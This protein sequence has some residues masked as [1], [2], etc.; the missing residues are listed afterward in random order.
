M[1]KEIRSIIYKYGI[2][3]KAYQKIGNAYIITSDN[4]KY[5]IKLNTN[6]YDI[7]K[8]LVSRD[9]LYFPNNYS[10]DSDNYDLL[11]YIPDLSVS[12][13]QKINDYIYLLGLLHKKTSYKREI[14]LD[15]IK[16]KYESITNKI[17]YLRDYYQN[18]NN[19]IDKEMFLSPSE[20][21]L[22]RN[23]SLIYAILTR[24]Q[25]L[26]N[27]LYNNI[28]NIKSIRVSLLH[29]N[30]SLSHLITNNRVYLISWD[31]AY[32]ASP[33]YEL[34]DFFR[35]YYHDIE[36][37]DLLKNYESVN[38]LDENE[39]SLL[40]ILLSLPKEIKLSNNTYHDTKII[41]NEINYLNKVYELLSNQEEKT[42]KVLENTS[43]L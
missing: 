37:N 33:I 40:L 1:N 22:V 13:E 24:S 26:L 34:E 21:L 14:D 2:H 7:Y 32:F 28:K 29:N 11:E 9:F 15:E 35:T 12:K 36:I 43:N 39:K 25:T 27:N 17:N 3:P 18:I 19:A 4:K 20:Y 6:N 23:I 8:Y 30:V 31:K 10:D 16:E 38:K 5:V 42:V 41:N